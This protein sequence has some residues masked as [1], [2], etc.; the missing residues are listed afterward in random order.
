MA[1]AFDRSRLSVDGGGDSVRVDE[2][3]RL[4]PRVQ[5]DIPEIA[6]T[7]MRP[8]SFLIRH[9]LFLP[10]I[11]ALIAV[12][13]VWIALDRTPPLVL[14]QGSITPFIVHPD[15][16][17]VSVTWQAEFSGRDCPG[18]TQ[19]EL[20]DSGKH[21]WPELKRARAGVFTPS[22]TNPKIGTVS[23]PPLQIPNMLPGAAEYRVTQFYYC[24]WLQRALNWPIIQ[25]SPFI[26]FEVER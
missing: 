6:V 10:Q 24:N 5:G 9:Y 16:K 17:A 14:I 8:L 23:T 12:Y 15:E 11:F 22:K 2:P 25:V 7:E 3:R 13:V 4:G 18:L 21:I 19:R 26:P 1:L 20:I